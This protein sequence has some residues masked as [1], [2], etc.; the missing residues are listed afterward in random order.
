MKSPT[1]KKQSLER[2]HPD[3]P[4]EF[5]AAEASGPWFEGGELAVIQEQHLQGVEAPDRKIGNFQ[6]ESSVLERVQLAGSQFGSAVWKDARFVNCDLANVRAHRITLVRVE[7]IDCRLTG[8]ATTALDWQ[9]V[10]IQN[11]DV[12][13]AQLRGGKFRRCEFE[14]SNFQEAD[15]Q[16]A[17]LT[18][19]TFRSCNLGRADLEGCQLQ[20]TD[21]RKSELEGM[22]VGVNDLRGAIVDPAQAMILARLLGLQIR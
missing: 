13:F 8:F 4:R 1:I 3:L 7:L 19:S 17:D 10:L 18:G 15:F 6:L 22:L 21:F 16:N 20:N 12:R 2:E 14:G 9:D 5:E 11:G